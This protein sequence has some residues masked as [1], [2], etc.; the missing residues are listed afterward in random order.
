[1]S[2][3]YPTDCSMTHCNTISKDHQAQILVHKYHAR[4]ISFVLLLNDIVFQRCYE[5]ELLPV[6]LLKQHYTLKIQ[7]LIK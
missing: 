4:M 1:M 6:I 5:I 3:D 2:L 7:M